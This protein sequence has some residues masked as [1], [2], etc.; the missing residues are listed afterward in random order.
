MLAALPCG[1]PL[2][3]TPQGCGIQGCIGLEVPLP[4]QVH[5]LG[6]QGLAQ[7]HS[8][9]AAWKEE[10]FSTMT[11]RPSQQVGCICGSQ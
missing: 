8:E 11:G 10:A 7:A 4:H 1:A 2:A 6:S 5:A 9:A 3:V